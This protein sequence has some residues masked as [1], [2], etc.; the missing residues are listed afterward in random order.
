MFR[1][2][3]RL[4][5]LTLVS[6]LSAACGS[7]DQNGN[8]GGGQAGSGGS[9][10]TAGW[11]LDAIDA[12]GAP[13]FVEL[14]EPPVAK[15]ATDL[16]F[17]PVR[18]GELWVTMREFYDGTPCTSTVKQGCTALE[19]TVLIVNDA[20]GPAPTSVVK[21]DSNAWHFM[22]RPTSIAFGP[23]DTFATCGEARTGNFEDSPVDFMGPTWWSSSEAIFAKDH[24]VPP[25]ESFTPNGSHL[26][27]LH[28]TPHCMGIAHERD[29][30]YWCF[31]GQIGALDRY[32]FKAPHPPGGSD[33]T[34]GELNRHLEGQFARVENVM[35][36]VALDAQTGFLYVADTGHKRV[37]VVDINSGTVT[38]SVLVQDD[39]GVKN[40]VEGTQSWDFVPTGTLDAPSGIAL[41]DGVV[42]VSDN[43]TSRIVAFDITNGRELRRLHTG[44]PPGT[45]GGIALG[46][47]DGKLYFVDMLSARVR[48]IEPNG[49]PQ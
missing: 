9:G 47:Q 42:F 29:G 3:T 46:P 21:K 2:A 6:L 31:N 23:G 35:S 7:D 15:V 48:R 37:A 12:S 18:P 33:H 41:G 5:P 25:G 34:D 36:H 27:M 44:L 8:P 13:R 1:F 4:G 17:N 28:G 14:W 38:G 43:A 11:Q 40:R 26:D 45:L 24:P 32:D 10:P 19:G 30:V 22:R 39:F 20:A 16:D 49:Q